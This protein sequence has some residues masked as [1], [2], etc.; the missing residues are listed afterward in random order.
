MP[1]EDDVLQKKRVIINWIM[2][3][4]RTATSR[5]GGITGMEYHSVLR[6]LEDMERDKV[7]VREKETNAV[8]WSMHPNWRMPPTTEVKS[9]GR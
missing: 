5:L 4:G 2:S 7:L 8:Y 6:L 3:F 1:A 9:D